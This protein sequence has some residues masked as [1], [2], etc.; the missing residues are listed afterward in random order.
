[1][2]IG[3]LPVTSLF[4]SSLACFYNETCI[5]EIQRALGFD[6]TNFAQNFVALDS[7][8]SSKFEPTTPMETIIK[9]LMVEEWT[10]VFNYSS[11]FD[12][13]KISSCSYS[14][15]ERNSFIAIVLRW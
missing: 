13:C 9:G 6:S 2:F 14:S 1:M 4:Q 12:Q 11:Y 3:C 5:F 15:L 10:Y 8:A 7:T